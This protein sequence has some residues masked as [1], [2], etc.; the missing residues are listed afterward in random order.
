MKY[1]SIKFKMNLISKYQFNFFSHFKSRATIYSYFEIGLKPA[2]VSCLTNAMPPP[3]IAL[4]SCSNP[5]TDRP[6]F[7]SALEKNFFGQRCRF[8]VSDVISEVVLGPFWL[9]L[10]GLGPNC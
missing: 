1:C 2:V 7:W 6:V 9:M 10:P 3:P 4:E 5:Q 8:F